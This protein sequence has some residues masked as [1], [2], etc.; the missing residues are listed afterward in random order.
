MKKLLLCFSLFSFQTMF[1][2]N[3][4]FELVQ[5]VYNQWKHF[6]FNSNSKCTNIYINDS[7]D[8]GMLNCMKDRFQNRN[9][10][11]HGEINENGKKTIDSIEFNPAEIRY[12]IEQLNTLNSHRW[13]E[14]IFPQSKKINPSEFDSLFA[15]TKFLDTES[16]LCYNVYTFS[17]PIFLRNNTFCLFY[18]EEKTF[19]T[20]EGEFY[21]YYLK[22]KKWNHYNR[23]CYKGK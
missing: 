4:N 18:A 9:K 14:K 20:V 6:S 11:Y 1:A 10:F 2:Q 8:V 3:E 22:K 19:S 5:E 12:I 21:L 23:I 17:N 15:S 13:N 7:V 16:L